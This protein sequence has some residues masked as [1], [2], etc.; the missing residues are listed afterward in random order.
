MALKVG[1]SD[2]K[3]YKTG[4]LYWRDHVSGLKDEELA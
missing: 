3:S 1:D 2:G 4:S